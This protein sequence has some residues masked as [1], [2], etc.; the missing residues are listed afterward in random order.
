MSVGKELKQGSHPLNT[1]AIEAGGSM[2]G[3]LG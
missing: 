3:G 2:V 1:R